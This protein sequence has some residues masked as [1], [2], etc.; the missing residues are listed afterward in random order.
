[1]ITS[2]VLAGFL[3]MAPHWGIAD[4]PYPDVGSN[5]SAETAECR[6]ARTLESYAR[7][8][9]ATLDKHDLSSVRIQGP[10]ATARLTLANRVETI[11]LERLGDEWRVMKVE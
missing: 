7:S 11:H 5:P 1:M 4:I 3:A 9:S 10:R 8:R 2:V 6:I